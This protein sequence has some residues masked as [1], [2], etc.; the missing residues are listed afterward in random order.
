MKQEYEED[1]RNPND[2]YNWTEQLVVYSHTLL[3][4]QL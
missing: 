2:R 4:L 1:E 3:R